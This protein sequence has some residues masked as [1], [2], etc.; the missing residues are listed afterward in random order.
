M[1]LFP[2]WEEEQ[3]KKSHYP[4]WY[5]PA[6]ALRWRNANVAMGL[7]PTGRPLLAPWND[8]R[9]GDCRWAVRF[10]RNIRSWY[11]CRLDALTWTGSRSTD[12]AVRWRACISFERG[13]ME[14]G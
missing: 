4:D 6:N 10:Q 11:K 14:E 7:H 5:Q 12:I 3:E 9:C 1:S 13:E 2:E 8:Q